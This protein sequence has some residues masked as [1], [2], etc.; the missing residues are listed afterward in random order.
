MKKNTPFKNDW[1]LSGKEYVTPKEKFFYS[2]LK[3]IIGMSIGQIVI[4]R[5]HYF[6]TAIV[7]QQ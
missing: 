1:K 5:N 2:F 3:A 4:E 6:S 7:S